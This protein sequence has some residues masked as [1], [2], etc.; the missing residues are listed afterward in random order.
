M[1]PTPVHEKSKK[2]NYILLAILVAVIVGLFAL[3]I[4]RMS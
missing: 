4:V 2:K 1:A 3:T